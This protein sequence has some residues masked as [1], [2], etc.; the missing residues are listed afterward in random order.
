MKVSAELCKALLIDWDGTLV[1]S[2]PI[3]ISNAA[4]LFG[5]RFG[6]ST[7]QV[8]A[9][10]ARHSGVPRHELFDLIAQDCVGRPLTDSEFTETS[11]AFTDLNRE[12]VARDA[13]IRSGTLAALETL[14]ERGVLL[15]IST[16]TTQDEIDALAAAFGVSAYCTEVMGSSPG[17]TKGPVHADH[18]SKRYGVTKLEMAGIG[19]DEQDMRLFRSAGITA[20]GITG[21]RSRPELELAGAHI[22]IDNLDE[23]VPDDS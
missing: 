9:S 5:S 2:L 10:Y 4:E 19:D 8:R 16:A 22:V 6:S 14:N 11:A 20:I 1:D 17:F 23:V 3:K 7:T 13:E 12:R 15:F 18:V 21:T